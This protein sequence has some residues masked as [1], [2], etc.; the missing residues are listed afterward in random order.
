[1][2]LLFEN[3]YVWFFGRLWRENPFE[4]HHMSL[5]AVL[6]VLFAALLHAT[7]NALIKSAPDRL[8]VL[9]LLNVGHVAFGIMLAVVS[10]IPDLASW[11]FIAASTL[12]HF[13]YYYLLYQS[14]RLGDLSQVYPIARGMSPVLVALGAQ[15]FAGETLPVMAWVG[16]LTASG[17]IFLL[18]G[19]LFGGKVSGIAVLAAMGTGVMIASYSLVD[20]LGVR[21][22]GS[23]T[24]YIG[25]LFIFE[26]LAA[27]FIFGRMGRRSF[28]LS[29]RT[30]ILGL[31]GGLV[32]ALAYG[33]V[34][35]VKSLAPLAMVS[36]LRETSV[37]IA[38]LI[39]VMLLG[40]RPWRLR[41]V[42]SIIVAIGVIIMGVGAL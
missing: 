42:A 31:T 8:A 13:G 23:A 18:S 7:W 1:M 11:G 41:L 38:A 2:P 28:A 22:A 19:N 33:L 39:G 26:G 32:S 24:A 4:K 34:I 27:V 35:Y 14:Y 30:W 21:L 40:E 6:I 36:T 16:V 25:W 10:P 3:G 20:G 37:V 15:I 9:G 5:S 29:R 17:G 12:I